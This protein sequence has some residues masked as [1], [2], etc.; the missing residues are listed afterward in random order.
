MGASTSEAQINVAIEVA[1][2][3]SDA[4]QGKGIRNAANF[5][6]VSAQEYKVLEPYVA[7]A[8]KMGLFAGQLINGGISEIKVTYS[9]V[10]NKHKVDPVTMA[11]V[12]G[13]LSPV[14]GETVNP[15]NALDVAGSRGINVQ[16]IQSSK[17]EEF[18]NL[19]SAEIITDKE[20]FTVWGTL[21]GNN[22]PRVVKVNDVYVEAVPAGYMLFINNN[23]KPGIVGA[24]GTILAKD[25]INIAGITFGRETAGGLAISVVNVDNEVSEKTIEEIRQTKDVLFAK[26]IKV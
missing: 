4:L 14:L 24:V 8:D 13:L 3:E 1:E 2:A 25:N 15:I 7:L 9:G 17:E 21:S 6:S 23:D 12:N 5:P 22:Q 11:F 16:A 20:T 26:L 10:L 19:V 18:V